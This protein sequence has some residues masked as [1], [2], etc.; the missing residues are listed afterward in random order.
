MISQEIEFHA[1]KKLSDALALMQRH[2]EDA[3][4]LA[5]GMSLVPIMTLGLVQA[6]VIISLNHIPELDYISDDRNG[7]RIG[8][9][10][11]HYKVRG[12]DLV[13]K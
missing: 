6:K 2:G 11:R 4:L 8:A 12:S 7:L 13:K 3:R 9:T 10:T 1:P 5:G